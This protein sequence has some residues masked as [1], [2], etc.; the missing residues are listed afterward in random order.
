MLIEW[1]GHSCF[2]ITSQGYSLVL[3]PYRPD[4]I[5]GLGQYSLEADAVYCSHEH[6][7]HNYREAVKLS[8]RKNLGTFQVK[9]LES[10]HDAEKGNKRGKNKITLLE[11]EGLKIAH[12][13]DLGCDLTD[14][15]YNTL[16]GLD[17][18]MIPVG[19]YYTID[20][21][22]AKSI[23]D[24][25]KPCVIIPMHFRGDGFGPAPIAT[26]VDF[27]NLFEKD[28]SKYY[29]NNR[30]ELTSATLSH[31]AVLKYR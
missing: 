6:G 27:T 19:G 25:V 11:S 28:Q 30:F 1:Y 8:G 31:V 24:R 22:Q 3:D 15:Q 29:P 14:E 12:L 13:G 21:I 5:T 20:A 17:L 18:I 2:K 26:V 9:I 7:D 4:M 10:Y 16:Q 23:C